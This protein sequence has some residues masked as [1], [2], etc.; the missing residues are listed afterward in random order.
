MEVCYR[1][2]ARAPSPRPRTDPEPGG[3][4]S[5]EANCPRYH[6]FACHLS[7]IGRSAAGIQRV[8]ID[9]LNSEPGSCGADEPKLVSMVWLSSTGCAKDHVAAAQI[10]V[11]MAHRAII[12]ANPWTEAMDGFVP[13]SSGCLEKKD[14]TVIPSP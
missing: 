9:V 12:H 10:I 1:Y 8:D 11:S 6:N 7:L 13:S 14:T 4:V 5:A 2:V 3:V